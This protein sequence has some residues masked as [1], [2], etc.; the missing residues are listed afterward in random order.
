MSRL[1]LRWQYAYDF[2]LYIPIYEAPLDANAKGLSVSGFGF[3]LV[4]VVWYGGQ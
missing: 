3:D 1:I 4:N 2:E